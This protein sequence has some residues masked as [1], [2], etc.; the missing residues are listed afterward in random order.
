MRA[1]QPLSIVEDSPR[2]R[3]R[4][5]SLQSRVTRVLDWIIGQRERP[6]MI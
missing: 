4:Y 3:G 2:N 6:E 1:D 5:E